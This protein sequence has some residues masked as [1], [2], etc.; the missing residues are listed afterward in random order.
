MAPKWFVMNANP[1]ERYPKFYF[2]RQQAE[3]D[4]YLRDYYL[5]F[6]HIDVESTVTVE[7]RLWPRWKT[8]YNAYTLLNFK[9][10]ELQGSVVQVVIPDD[11]ARR[12]APKWYVIPHRQQYKIYMF[13]SL[14]EV[15]AFV[16][17]NCEHQ[18]NRK[19]CASCMYSP[20]LFGHVDGRKEH[21]KYREDQF[22]FEETSF[23]INEKF[24]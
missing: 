2:T 12:V 13:F 23:Q 9:D 17:V 18:V 1:R 21:Y 4:N 8:E 20:M 15:K 3:S 22:D 19:D 14:E 5:I 7:S 11:E 10:K 16:K 6:G 24:T